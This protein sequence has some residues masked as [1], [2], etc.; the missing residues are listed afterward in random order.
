[1]ATSLKVAGYCTNRGNRRASPDDFARQSVY[2]DA[3]ACVPTCM[4]ADCSLQVPLWTRTA[5]VWVATAPTSPK[6]AT[7]HGAC[8]HVRGWPSAVL[9]VQC[10]TSEASARRSF[11]AQASH[12]LSPRS[13]ISLQIFPLLWGQLAVLEVQQRHWNG[14]EWWV[15]ERYPSLLRAELFRMQR[16]VCALRLRV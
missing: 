5:C 16:C 15:C 4:C 3:C 6:G 2:M 11:S 1:M 9:R 8:A 13:P 10:V 14:D 12:S 7:V